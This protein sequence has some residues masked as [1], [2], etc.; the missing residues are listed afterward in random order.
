MIELGIRKGNE[1]ANNVAANYVSNFNKCGFEINKERGKRGDL[2]Y[3]MH[4][5]NLYLIEGYIII[6]IIINGNEDICRSLRTIW[7]CLN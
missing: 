4:G 6:T 5:S 3:D 2:I 1:K 7:I